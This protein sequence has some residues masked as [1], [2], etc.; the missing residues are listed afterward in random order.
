[1]TQ[2]MAKRLAARSVETESGQ[3]DDRFV[4]EFHERQAEVRVAIERFLADL[5][6]DRR[7]GKVIAAF[8]KQAN[9]IGVRVR[10]T[11]G[12]AERCPRAPFDA[13]HDERA[14][15]LVEEQRLVAKIDKVGRGIGLGLDDGADGVQITVAGRLRLVTCW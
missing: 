12:I 1:M 11:D 14:S 8:E 15:R 3:V 2:R 7:R 9:Q 10:W 4:A 6:E 5:V 13:V